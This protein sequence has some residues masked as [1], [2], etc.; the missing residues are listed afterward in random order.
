VRGAPLAA[1][2]VLFLLPVWLSAR[3]AD[4]V[5]DSEVVEREIWQ[6]RLREARAEVT[7]ARERF[8][9]ADLAYK[10]MRHHQRGRGES[11]AAVLE[12][13]RQAR[14]A[15]EEAERQLRELPEEARRSG[16][17]PGWLRL[18]EEPAAPSP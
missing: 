5:P 16:V 1:L 8:E 15:L 6:E 4:P 14:V 13:R 18:D 12:E 7:R 9:A 11:K 3:A 2:L 17:P 10:R